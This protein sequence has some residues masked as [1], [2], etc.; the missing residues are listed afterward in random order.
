MIDYCVRTASGGHRYHIRQKISD[1]AGACLTLY[2]PIWIPGSYTR[3]DFAKHV[4]DM[5]M[6]AD[7]VAL[8]WR[9]LDPST[10]Q[11]DV[12]S[13]ASELLLEY[14]V[15]ARDV[16]VRGC[17][18][19]H[20]RGLFNPCCACVAVQ[21]REDDRHRLALAFDS[22]RANWSCCGADMDQGVWIADDYD[23]LIDTPLMLGAALQ[24]ASFDVSGKAHE[25]V[26]SGAVVSMDMDRLVADVRTICRAAH[27]VFAAWPEQVGTYRF[28]L[29]V[30]DHVYGGLEHRS[31]TLL[32]AP[33]KLLPR[34]D[35]SPSQEYLRLLGLCSHEYFHTWNV[36][37]LKPRD[38]QPYDLRCE[39]PSE[40][41]WLFEGFTAFFDNWLLVRSGVISAQQYWRILAEDISNHLRRR[42][43]SKQTL[44][45]SSFEAWTKLYNGGEDAINSST[46]YYVHGSLFALCLDVFLRERSDEQ[47]H[48]PRVM[49]ELWSQYQK[50]G[51]GLDEA[52][53]R[54]CVSAWLPESARADFAALMQRGLHTTVE[55]PLEDAL[56][57]LGMRLQYHAAKH[58]GTPASSDPGFRWREDHGVW[59]VTALDETSA[60]AK[61]GVGVDDVLVAVNQLQVSGDVLREQL[62][63][64]K[65]WTNVRIH[66]FR[67]RVLQGFDVV[68][69]D[70]EINHAQIQ[71]DPHA[72]AAAQARCRQ[73]LNLAL[74]H[75]TK[76]Q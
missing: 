14:S 30:T 38:Y 67:D 50:D 20:Q 10:W 55:L 18:L 7:D 61:V 74:E 12:P 2:L 22:A 75:P 4:R 68:L 60:A 43:R 5:R 40:M 27:E 46:N 72:S 24:C 34:R 15:Y 6:F 48:L 17:Y 62:C 29:H 37:D 28:M 65:A 41:L 16:S 31:S 19:D 57:A 1:C 11:V 25:M 73:W 26:V 52:G 47:W 49:R 71:S 51:V 54:D 58:Q 70:A 8:D 69:Q 35:L 66:V 32:M 33:R 56:A 9:L 45:H 76:E 42:G 59:R 36:K 23:A 39:Q 3:R 21:G 63:H 13:D 64:G 44:A 53:F